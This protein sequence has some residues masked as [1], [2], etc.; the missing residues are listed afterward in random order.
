MPPRQDDSSAVL[1][2]LLKKSIPIPLR[3]FYVCYALCCAGYADVARYAP[4]STA[5]L[6]FI[7]I[8]ETLRTLTADR[9]ESGDECRRKKQL[10][11]SNTVVHQLKGMLLKDK[12]HFSCFF[13][14]HS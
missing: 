8:G 3:A 13:R 9:L 2:L 12:Q 14:M 7:R 10:S 4:Q 5:A 1:P 11:L 6:D